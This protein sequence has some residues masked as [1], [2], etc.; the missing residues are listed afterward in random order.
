M[1][2][3]ETRE[4]N[5]RLMHKRRERKRDGLRV[6][7]EVSGDHHARWHGATLTGPMGRSRSVLVRSVGR[8]HAIER[9][10][11]SIDDRQKDKS[12]YIHDA[13][14]GDDSKTEGKQAE[15]PCLPLTEMKGLLLRDP[16]RSWRLFR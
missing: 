10:M 14:L 7:E 11:D 8:S 9:Q 13:R 3:G 2:W 12:L 1:I 5:E 6:S 15:E 16:V 4:I